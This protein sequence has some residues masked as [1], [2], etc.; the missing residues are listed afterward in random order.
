MLAKLEL[1]RIFNVV[2]RNKSF[3]RAAAELYMTQ[4]AISQAISKLENELETLLFNRIPKGVTLT[5]EGELLHEYVNSALGILDAGEEKIAEFRNLQTG[6]LRIGVGDTISRYFLLPYLEAFH[7]KYP[8]IKL[9]VLNGTTIEILTFIK[10]GEADLGICN[11]PIVDEHLQVIPC[12]EIHDIFV[13]GEKYKNLVKK[14]VR[15]EMLMK[16]P[17]IFLEKRAN[18]RIYVESYLKE[19][20]YAISPEFELGSHDLVLEFAKI[21]LGVGSVTREF[22]KDYLEKGILYEIELQEPIPKRNI[23]IVHLK[24]V[25]LSRAARKFIMIVDPAIVH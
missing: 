5:N 11:L 8:G 13:C 25:P 9:K 19:Q 1:Y 6:L 15:L 16:L 4:P 12:K 10:A 3:S 20:G 24:S 17:L 23:G 22:S 21:N 7:L 18:S 14:P 2:S